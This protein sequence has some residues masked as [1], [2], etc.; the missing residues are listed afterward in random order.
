MIIN[1]NDDIINFFKEQY[2][3][4]KESNQK[5]KQMILNENPQ[6]IWDNHYHL[7]DHDWLVYWKDNI[8]FYELNNLDKTNYKGDEEK[9]IKFI[10]E[11][12]KSKEI[13]KL[14]NKTI[15]YPISNKKIIDPMQTF[16]L[17]SDEAWNLFASN[18]NTNYDGRVSILGGNRKILIKFNE[19]NYS[20]KYL[21]FKNLFGEFVIVFNPPENEYKENI[22]DDVAKEEINAWMDKIGFK[23][24]VEQFTINKYKIPF[25]IKLK[26]NSK[27]VDMDKSLNLEEDIIESDEYISLS[28]LTMSFWY[29]PINGNTT[30]LNSDEFTSFLNDTENIKNIRYV[31]KYNKT[32]YIIA[33]MRCLSMVEPLGEYFT[34]YFKHFKIFSRFQSLSLLNLIGE[35]FSNIYNIK[36][37]TPYAPKVFIQNIKKKININEEQDPYLFLKYLLKYINKKLNNLDNEIN[38]NYNDIKDAL[39]KEPYYP[40]IINIS[41]KNNSII[42]EYFFGLMLETYNCDYCKV[43][44]YQNIKKIKII[45]IDLISIYHYLKVEKSDSFISKEIDDLLEFYF[46]KNHFCKCENNITYNN[47]TEYKYCHRCNKIIN[48]PLMYNKCSNCKKQKKLI[49]R[50]ILEY[51]L[52]LMIK[53]KIGEY[54]EKE[55]FING[56]NTN[57]EI[58][59]DKINIIKN[60]LSNKNKKYNDINNYEYNLISMV[61]YSKIEEKIKFFS[62]CKSLFGPLNNKYW[63]SFVS[64]SKPKGLKTYYNDISQPYILFYKLQKKNN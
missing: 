45:E 54:K 28:K 39:V 30:F 41:N 33:V 17:I 42:G 11:N 62:I 34:G 18:N 7:I 40:K 64:N 43:K 51:P 55:G 44:N 16:D 24:K 26:M 25:D 10:R 36:E 13:A 60:Y 22:L 61:Q 53:L 37:K 15:Y 35:Y 48:S 52:F 20:V 4:Y 9:I 63:I 49:E 19:N 12:A 58:V 27:P 29:N 2:K 1:D 6:Y 59:Y 14:N 5:L 57:L 46:L 50:K 3:K 23:D 31:Q 8:S 47:P 38:F 56:L 21:T 32:S